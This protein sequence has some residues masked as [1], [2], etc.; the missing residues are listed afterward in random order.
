MGFFTVD[1]KPE[2]PLRVLSIEQMP[3][4]E[5]R[6]LL[7]ALQRQQGVQLSLLRLGASKEAVAQTLRGLERFPER[8]EVAGYD[9]VVLG[10][11][12]TNHVDFGE[13]AQK[14]LA[15]FVKSKGGGLIVLAGRHSPLVFKGTP[16]EEVLPLRLD[17]VAKKPEKPEE[18]RFA[19]SAA[20]R[21]HPLYAIAKDEKASE[22][23]WKRLPPFLACPA[24]CAP[25]EGVNVLAVHPALKLDKND[26]PLLIEQ[27]FGQ[28]RTLYVGVDETWRWR[29]EEEGLV[30]ERFWLTAVKAVLR[31]AK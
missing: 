23:F 15:S 27:N 8:K 28:G 30:H 7:A 10:D 31:A 18:F 21:K 19:W 11:V 29:P 2:R 16:L 12:L 6:F 9:V 1:E 25:R 22:E 14:A 26:W 5:N 20:G 24:G 13:E 17:A 4:W 3:R